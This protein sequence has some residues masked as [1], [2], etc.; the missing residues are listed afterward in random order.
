LRKTVLLDRYQTKDNNVLFDLQFR[1]K[2]TLISGD[3]GIGKT[4]LFKA[5]E[6]DVLLGKNMIICLNYD[7]IPS[8]NIE[9]TLNTVKNKVIVI[10]NGDISLNNM[11][12]ARV[13]LDNQNQY[14]IFAHSTDGF[15]P[16]EASIARLNIRNGRGRLEHLLQKG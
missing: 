4:M 8:G 7:D 5:I 15:I 12:K 2:L 1:D 14:V 13:S 16:N 3:S 6:R 9:H 11:Q 10:D